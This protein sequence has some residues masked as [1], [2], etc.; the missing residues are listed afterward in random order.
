M[1]GAEVIFPHT[2]VYTSPAQLKKLQWTFNFEET[3]GSAVIYSVWNPMF[4]DPL[5]PDL[6]EDIKSKQNMNHAPPVKVFTIHSQSSAES[7]SKRFNHQINPPAPSTSDQ[8]PAKDR[9]APTWPQH[10]AAKSLQRVVKA[11]LNQ[12]QKPPQC[13]CIAK[14]NYSYRS[15]NMMTKKDARC[16]LRMEANKGH[17]ARRKQLR[18]YSMVFF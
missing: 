10:R 11:D 6:S 4:E 14:T 17:G 2:K 12:K 16:S 18:S 8:S 9:W 7:S 15:E 3:I 5:V 13:F 1:I